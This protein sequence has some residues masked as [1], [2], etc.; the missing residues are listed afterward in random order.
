MSENGDYPY[1][2]YR[3]FK[4][5]AKRNTI[6]GILW[7]SSFSHFRCLEDPLR[8]DEQEGVASG[9]I[10]NGQYFDFI[11]DRNMLN[12][13]Y[14]LCFTECE[15]APKDWGPVRLHLQRPEWL[16]KKVK[17]SMQHCIVAFKKVQYSD[18]TA[19]PK[20]PKINEIIERACFTKPKMFETE[21]EW[22]LLLILPGMRIV[23]KTLEV[24]IGHPGG[25]YNVY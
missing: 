24:D 3:H 14:I 13:C 22:R 19:Y 6:S 5:N 9:Q 18:E 12:P 20:E 25:I 15:S 4:E 11:S 10:A 8:R 1:C 17:E 7:F 2:L 23:N 16:K 21:R